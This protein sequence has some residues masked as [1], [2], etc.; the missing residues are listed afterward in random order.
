VFS[1]RFC[2][3]VTFGPTIMSFFVVATFVQMIDRI[4][5]TRTFFFRSL[6]VLN[7]CLKNYFVNFCSSILA[8]SIF[9][10]STFLLLTREAER[11]L[12]ARFFGTIDANSPL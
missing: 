8:S 9:F 3:G 4:Q 11:L 10:H 6:R 5:R 1:V 12:Y 2:T 7:Y